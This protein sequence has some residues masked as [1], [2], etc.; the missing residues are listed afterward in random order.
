MEEINN[1]AHWEKM[2]KEEL[3]KYYDQK[4][5]EYARSELSRQILRAAKEDEKMRIAELEAQLKP[6]SKGPGRA[7]L[8]KIKGLQRDSQSKPDAVTV[9]TQGKYYVKNGRHYVVYRESA[10]SGLGETSTTLMYS[11]DG[12]ARLTRAGEQALRMNFVEGKREIT[13]YATPF[14]ILNLGFYTNK[15]DF[16]LSSK[17]GTLKLSYNLDASTQVELNTN[18][19]LQFTFL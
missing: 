5:E 12:S 10:E 13:H 1:K 4:T 16:R 17:G 14:G 3:E 18:L 11:P 2:S 9:T 6:H 19:E 8:I 7:V 15:V